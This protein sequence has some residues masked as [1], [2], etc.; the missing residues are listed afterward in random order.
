MQRISVSEVEGKKV[1]CFSTGL[2]P[3]AFAR[4]KMSQSLTENGFVVHPNGKIEVWRPSGVHDLNGS[5]RVLGPLFNGERLDQLIK[6]VKPIVESETAPAAQ[7]AVAGAQKALQGVVYWLRAKML[8]G[9]A[10]S[11]LNPGAAFVCCEDGGEPYSKGSAFFAPMNLSNRCLY[12]EYEK[13]SNEPRTGIVSAM[14]ETA[15]V[16]DRFNCPDLIG[17]EAV[18]FCAGAMLYRIFAKANPYPYDSTIFQDMREGV[19]V[20]PRLAFPSLDKKLRDL[21][22]AALYLPV[23]KKRTGKSGIEI[24]TDLL[25]VLLEKDSATGVDGVISISS[26]LGEISQEDTLKLEKEKKSFLF[27]QNNSVKVRRFIVRNKYPL[28]G[29]G[30]ALFF[31]LLIV[32]STTRSFNRRPTTTGMASDHVIVAYYDA[33]SALDHIFME[34]CTQGAGRDD[35]NVAASFFAVTKTRQAYEFRAGG[36]IIPARVWRESGGELPAPDVFGVTDLEIEFL[37]G[38]EDDDMIIYRTDYLLW[39]PNEFGRRRN[40]VITLRRDK[41]KNWR[42]TEILRTES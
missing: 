7:Q 39:A 10:N 25:N 42:I 18:A 29:T 40:D 14:R 36:G 35:I 33:F 13:A 20:P 31:V 34:A 37:A 30:A 9:D 38:A 26:L 16:Q 28:I 41:R 6:N 24:I 5:M 12:I 17:M 19:F 23:D 27:R 3:R 8:L 11:T 2:D 22:L 21:I 1:I 4:T 15:L 32:F